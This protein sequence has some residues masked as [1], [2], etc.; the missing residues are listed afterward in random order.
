MIKILASIFFAVIIPALMGNIIWYILSFK[1]TIIY[2]LMSPFLSYTSI[3]AIVSLIA[4][5][6]FL[7]LYH[8]FK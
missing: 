8:H 6:I 1:L 5:E 7:S 3:S 2:A 4:W